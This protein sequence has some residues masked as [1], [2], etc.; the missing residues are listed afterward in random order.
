MLLLVDDDE[1]ELVELHV[2]REQRVR[3]D[4]DVDL[5]LG[6]FGLGL[7]RLFGADKARKLRDPHRQAGKALAEAAEMLS[8]QQSRR[9]DNRDLRTG[10]GGEIGRA[11]VRTPVTFL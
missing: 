9:D 5:A 8:R 6:Q 11:H 4:D 1:A 10:K 7:L 2:F 3:A